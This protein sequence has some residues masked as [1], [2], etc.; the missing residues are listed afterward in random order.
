MQPPFSVG[1]S[2]ASSHTTPPGGRY[3]GEMR[4]LLAL[5]AVSVAVL[6]LTASNALGHT[7]SHWWNTSD[8]REIIDWMNGQRAWYGHT[9]LSVD[10]SLT[11]IA[12]AQ[13][14]RIAACRCLYHQNLSPLLR[15]GWTSAGENVAYASSTWSAHVALSYSPGHLANMNSP[16]YRGVGVGVTHSAGRVYVVQVFGGF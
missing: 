13:A 14:D 16:H 8:E 1:Y 4:R 6:A 10:P 9:P 7:W 5:V 15:Q 3:L 12:R 11:L 2:N